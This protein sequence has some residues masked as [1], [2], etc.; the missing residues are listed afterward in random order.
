MRFCYPPIY[1]GGECT[2]DEKAVSALKAVDLDNELGGSP[3]QVRV[4]QGSEPRH[5]LKMF[6]GQLVIHSGGKV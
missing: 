2:N 5:F 6:G 4:T 3:V 1:Q